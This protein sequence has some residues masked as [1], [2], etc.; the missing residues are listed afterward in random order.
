MI[1]LTLQPLLVY[2]HAMPSLLGRSCLIRRFYVKHAYVV[3]ELNLNF[4]I[5]L[6][7]LLAFTVISDRAVKT[8]P[9]FNK[10]TITKINVNNNLIQFQH[11]EYK[12]GMYITKYTLHTYKCGFWLCRRCETTKELP[13]HLSAD[14]C[15]YF[16]FCFLCLLLQ[17]LGFCRA[18]P[19][20][21]YRA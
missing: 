4:F 9:N 19:T 3:D 13:L 21:N 17:R 10:Y 14:S 15:V 16:G 1:C 11:C 6:K 12:V 8:S 18:L 7:H 2:E 5:K 20:S